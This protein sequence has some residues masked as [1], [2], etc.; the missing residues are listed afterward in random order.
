MS[1]NNQHLVQSGLFDSTPWSAVL[2]AGNSQHASN[3]SSLEALCSI[4]W[5]PLHAYVRRKV[6]DV[7]LAQDL[8]QSF[9]A[10]LLKGSSLRLADPARGRFRTFLIQAFEW[11]LANEFRERNALKRGGAVQTFPLDF[12]SSGH[13]PMDDSSLSAEQAFERDWAVTLLSQ[14][15]Q[16]LKSE[17]ADADRITQFETLKVFLTGE[18]PAGGYAS[19]C[20]ELNLSEPA[21]RMAVS[22]LRS[23]YRELLK[24]EIQKTVASSQDVDDEIQHLFRALNPAR[25]R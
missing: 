21:A 3:R 13:E 14:T 9:F 22:R 16:R 12:S 24:D 8:T 1:E 7:H 4:Y 10:R 17:H 6:A 15:M 11:H 5:P 25:T 23:R 20:S 2:A 19:I 18:G